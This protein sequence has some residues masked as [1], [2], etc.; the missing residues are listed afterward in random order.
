MILGHLSNE[1]RAPGWFGFMGES[2]YLLV[3]LWG[4]Q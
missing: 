4:L 1:Q 2:Y 3:V